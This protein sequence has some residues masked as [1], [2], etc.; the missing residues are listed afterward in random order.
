MIFNA[1]LVWPACALV[2]AAGVCVAAQQVTPPGTA[3]PATASRG[4]TLPITTVRPIEPPATPL[5]A[6]AASAGETQF[7]FLVYGDSRS[8][9]DGQAL[10]PDHGVIVDT[11]VA[12]IHEL[13]STAF[14]VR[15]VLQTGDAVANGTN[16]AAWNVSFSPLIEKLTRDAGVPYFLAAGNHDV[17]FS[18]DSR[19]VGL[20]NTLSALSR[21][22]P[23]EGSPRRLHDYP[24]YAIGYGNLFAIAIDSNVAADPVQLAWVTD[25]LEHLDRVRYRHIVAFFHHPP[26]S[27]GPHG[28]ASPGPTVTT[29][30]NIERQTAAIRTLYT[31]LFRRFHVRMTLSGHDHFYD[32]WI[33]R[34]ADAGVSY[35]RD[36]VVTGGGG[37][38]IYTYRGE[39]DVRAYL[40]AGA[41]ENVRVEHPMRPG[42]TVAENPHHFVVIRVDGGRLSLEVI[43]TGPADYKPYGDRAGV[44]LND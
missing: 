17:A 41:S 18:L 25:Q 32:H 20:R 29:D 3:S 38:P 27:S 6:E 11:M 43:G 10:Q 23:P 21:L 30:D 22:I 26:F 9:V 33:E 37:A 7:S 15:F 28:G 1:K 39:P 24:T 34:Y 4:T 35:R 16:G 19:P 8:Q 5:P 42:S 31:P 14:P 12:K 2:A 40:A 13:S 36:D 44:Q